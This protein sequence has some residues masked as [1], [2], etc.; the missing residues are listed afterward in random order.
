ME[1]KGQF[2]IV[3]A[4]LLVLIISTLVSIKTYS[5]VKSQPQTLEEAGLDLREES[6]RILDY[7]VYNQANLTEILKN[8]TEDEFAEYF[9]RKTDYTN[10]T[11]I[12]GNKKD[13]Y[14]VEYLKN[15]ST[16]SV[17][18]G[19]LTYIPIK[20]T[21]IKTEQI[22]VK[23]LDV[24]PTDGNEIIGVTILNNSYK[25]KLKENEVFYFVIGKEQNG[26]VFIEKN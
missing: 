3:A 24:D 21:L 23:E 14:K 20:H 15:D 10:L 7:G 8:F 25:F 13:L 26:E 6:S 4:I 17:S 12:Y 11:F 9:L 18:L 5:Y 19:T 22:N 16:S 2:Y 1:K